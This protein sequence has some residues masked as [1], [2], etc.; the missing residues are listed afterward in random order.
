MSLSGWLSTFLH[1]KAI[2]KPEGKPLYWYRCRSDQLAALEQLILNERLSSAPAFGP[3]L[4]LVAAE[5][6][7]RDYR[8]GPWSW[9]DCG[10][11]VSQARTLFGFPRFTQLIIAGLKFP[12][13][14][15]SRSA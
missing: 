6:F 9:E 14:L 7:R 10:R 2:I 8:E 11:S 13:A 3:C 15:G 12:K 4:V 5:R 1:E